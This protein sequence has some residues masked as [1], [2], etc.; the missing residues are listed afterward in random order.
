MGGSLPTYYP[1]WVCQSIKPQHP[2]GLLPAPSPTSSTSA[3]L[4]PGWAPLSAKF[5][6]AGHNH[7]AAET[8]AAH[9]C[10]L[11]VLQAASI[12]LG[13]LPSSRRTEADRQ[14][15]CRPSP[16]Y[17][18]GA[19]LTGARCTW[20]T[21]RWGSSQPSPQSS[22]AQPPAD[23]GRAGLQ[24]AVVVE[25]TWLPAGCSSVTAGPVDGWTNT[26]LSKLW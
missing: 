13:V 3:E 12:A 24:P 25:V 4:A 18:H 2:Q 11:P 21:S 20:C 19:A 14:L 26:A 5:R 10:L 8:A 23:S 17:A 22:A 7:Q 6:C 15:L 16:P 1:M 9:V